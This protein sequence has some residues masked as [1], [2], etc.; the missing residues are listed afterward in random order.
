MDG[1]A[2]AEGA[3]L[4]TALRA[5]LGGGLGLLAGSFLATLVLRWP[6]GRSLGG[7]SACDHCGRPIP[8]RDLVPILSWLRLA[9]RCRGCGARIGALHPGMEAVAALMGAAAF[10]V[11]PGAGGWLGALFG[12][13]ILALAVLDA[14]HLWLPDRLTL[15]LL[16][17]GL[18]AGPAPLPDRALAA[19]IAGGGLL[20]V[21]LGYR[22][23]R[24]REGLGLG[25]VKLGAAL[26]SWLSPLLLPP[27]LL[28]ASLLGLLMAL[29]P[30]AREAIPFGACLGISA[31]GLW[32]W[33]ALR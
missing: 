24:G 20:L 32:L 2:V 17:L 22:W 13:T 3:A 12:W 5:L 4:G 9:G 7:R 33:S 23:W 15:P 28:G 30:S 18:A 6:E 31:W 27:L 29:R 19:A 10:A 25:D 8:L 16:A 14:R 21:L 1:L 11:A 26:G